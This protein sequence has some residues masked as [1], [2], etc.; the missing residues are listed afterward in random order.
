L[1]PETAEAAAA[2][3]AD[4]ARPLAHNGFKVKLVQRTIVRALL[5]VGGVR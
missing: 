1:R 5:S 4:G 2:L 3:A